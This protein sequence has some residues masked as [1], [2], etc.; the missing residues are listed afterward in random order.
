MHSASL[1]SSTGC[2]LMGPMWTQSFT[3]VPVV[4]TGRPRWGTSGA[5]MRMTAPNNSR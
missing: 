1:A 2:P 4:L 5:S 3:V